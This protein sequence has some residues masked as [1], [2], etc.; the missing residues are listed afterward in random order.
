M[1]RLTR[2]SSRTQGFSLVELLLVL[3][4]IGIIS[5]IAIPSYL[6]QRKR[7]RIIG[8]AIANAEALRMGLES[9]R[10]ENGIYGTAGAYDWKAD[11]SATTG[12]ALV[13]TFNPAGASKMNYD[14]VINADGVTYTLTVTA[15]EYGNAV[16]YQID[17]AG[18]ELARMH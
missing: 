17:Q 14:V 13:P 3:A 8:D 12:L 9:R 6:G 10:A 5:A 18:K 1:S 7:A 15:P 16:A 11:G 4:L 2:R